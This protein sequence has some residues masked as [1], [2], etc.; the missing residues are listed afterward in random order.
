MTPLKQVSS[1][2]YPFGVRDC[3]TDVIISSEWL[4]T[5]RRAGLGR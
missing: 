4:K 1:R 2:A 3:D 5:I